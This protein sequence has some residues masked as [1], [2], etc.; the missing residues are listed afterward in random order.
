M[1]HSALSRTLA[2]VQHQEMPVALALIGGLALLVG[3]AACSGGTGSL[4]EAEASPRGEPTGEAESSASEPTPTA[5]AAA[6]SSG[7]EGASASASTPA[8]NGGTSSAPTPTTSGGTGSAPTP[9]ASGGTGNENDDAPGSAEALN[10]QKWFVPWESFAS[11]STGETLQAPLEVRWMS[12]GSARDGENLVLA[13]A[14]ESGNNRIVT[15]SANPDPELCTFRDHAMDFP[16]GDCEMAARS[17]AVVVAT[18]SSLYGSNDGG[19]S[20]FE[21]AVLDE[22]VERLFISDTWVYARTSLH[23]LFAPLLEQQGL[24]LLPWTRAVAHIQGDV[25]LEV[26]DEE[27]R[28]LLANETLGSPRPCAAP[29]ADEPFALG[30]FDSR[31]IVACA[32]GAVAISEDFPVAP[33]SIWN[34]D[35]EIQWVGPSFFVAT[36]TSWY[37]TGTETEG[38]RVGGQ[39]AL[40]EDERIWGYAEGARMAFRVT[41]LG[42][43]MTYTGMIVEP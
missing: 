41:S 30:R 23:W 13:I 20:Y 33:F 43:G 6:E 37:S 39:T 27:V 42:L 34:F 11:T 21:I 28:L 16:C 19:E 18:D 1:P 31:V 17:S 40:A 10:E 15:L 12:A 29:S 2:R 22:P 36:E 5:G 3:L 35:G 32:D 25:A 4:E 14:T 24:T 38:H 7:P 26:T 9:T 8:A